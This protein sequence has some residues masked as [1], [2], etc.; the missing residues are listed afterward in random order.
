VALAGPRVLGF[1]IDDLTKAVTGGKLAGYGALF[2]RDRRCRRT[3]Q[4]IAGGFSSRLPRHS[5]TDMRNGFFAHLERLPLGYFQRT[6][7]AI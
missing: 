6:A 1:A 5:S 3:F 7:P 2:A 4:F